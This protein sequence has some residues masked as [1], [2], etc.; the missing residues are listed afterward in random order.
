MEPTSNHNTYSLANLAHI[1]DTDV[2]A[3]EGEGKAIRHWLYKS[4]IYRGI[5]DD[6]RKT[7][8]DIGLMDNVA[9]KGVNHIGVSV[10]ITRE[11]RLLILVFELK[12]KDETFTLATL[13]MKISPE[14][15]IIF[16]DTDALLPVI[17]V[18]E[19]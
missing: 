6:K 7:E 19:G 2:N 8:F 16:D 18:K 3:I 10:E 1:I 4:L 5:F 15:T 17:T 13:S 12:Y 14:T 9:V 11:H